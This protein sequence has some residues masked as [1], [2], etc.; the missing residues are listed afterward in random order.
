MTVVPATDRGYDRREKL[1]SWQI[2]LARKNGRFSF[3]R[4]DTLIIATD[5]PFVQREGTCLSS[6]SSR[7]RTSEKN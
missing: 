6:L 4:E 7:S 5:S 3:V 2:P 1:E